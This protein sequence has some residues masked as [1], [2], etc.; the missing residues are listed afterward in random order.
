MHLR[1]DKLICLYPFGLTGAFIIKLFDRSVD[2]TKFNEDMPLYPICRS[3]MNNNP[4][5]NTKNSSNGMAN[6]RKVSDQV[7]KVYFKSLKFLFR[8]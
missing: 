6:G 8:L 7:R 3:W 1:P 2:L 5:K 4:L